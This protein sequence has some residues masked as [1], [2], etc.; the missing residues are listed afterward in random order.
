VEG[1]RYCLE[2][3]TKAQGRF[4]AEAPRKEV[5]GGNR[6]KWR[7]RTIGLEKVWVNRDPLGK[8]AE[9]TLQERTG[10]TRVAIIRPTLRGILR[11]NQRKNPQ[12]GTGLAGG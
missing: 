5:L 6:W 2:I 12:E 7:A 1:G 3:L 4:R 10:E 8:K 11:K 9:G